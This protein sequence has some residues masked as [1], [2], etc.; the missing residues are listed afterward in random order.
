MQ[1]FTFVFGLLLFAVVRCEEEITD[2][3][4]VLV[5]TNDN[6]DGAIKK[7]KHILVEFCKFA[8]YLLLGR[9]VLVRLILHSVYSI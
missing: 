5:L 6:F 1:L 3:E 4:D 9:H 8:L 2:D 7:H